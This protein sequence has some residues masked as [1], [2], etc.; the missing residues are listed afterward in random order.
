MRAQNELTYSCYPLLTR[1]VPCRSPASSVM[2]VSPLKYHSKR[3]P[4]SSSSSAMKPSRDATACM[5]MVPMPGLTRQGAQTHRSGSAQAVDLERGFSY[6][7]PAGVATHHARAHVAVCLARG[8]VA[9]PDPERGRRD[10]C[11]PSS[12]PVLAAVGGEL[13]RCPGR[14]RHADLRRTDGT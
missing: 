11:Q 14:V 10:A 1:N 4:T 2:V 12:G 8:R 6:A 7:V 13:E 5:I 3:G 9:V